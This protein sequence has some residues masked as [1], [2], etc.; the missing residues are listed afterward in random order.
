MNLKVTPWAHIFSH[1]TCLKPFSPPL[2]TDSCEESSY[3]K[4]PTECKKWRCR[5]KN[6]HWKRFAVG[7]FQGWGQG[8]PQNKRSPPR[9]HCSPGK[10]NWICSLYSIFPTVCGLTK[11]LP[12]PHCRSFHRKK[13]QRSAWLISISYMKTCYPLSPTTTS[14]WLNLMP[15]SGRWRAGLSAPNLVEEVR[16]FS[17][18]RKWN[19]RRVSTAARRL[20]QIHTA[21][22]IKVHRVW[23]KCVSKPLPSL[24][25]DTRSQT[26]Y[27]GN[28]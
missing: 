2:I 22:S 19:L 8:D 20:M 6:L 17:Y 5:N 25:R 10:W 12:V 16:G 28:V 18:C 9:R 24:H 21:I 14:F 1:H 27:V 7:V 26:S 4:L 3:W 23:L 11:Q 13:T 15:T